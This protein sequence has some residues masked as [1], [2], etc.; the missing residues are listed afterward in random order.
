[1]LD[2][3]HLQRLVIFEMFGIFKILF[4]LIPGIG[5]LMTRQISKGIDLILLTIL[6]LL[7]II[8]QKRTAN[9]LIGYMQDHIPFYLGL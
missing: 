7:P 9:I 4:L 8:F 6:A 3:N 1:M 5:Q 2:G